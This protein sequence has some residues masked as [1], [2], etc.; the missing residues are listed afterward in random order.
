MNSAALLASRCALLASIAAQA[1][2]VTYERLQN[3]EP[4]NWLMNHHDYSSQRFSALDQINKSNIKNLQARLRHRA[5]GHL[6]QR[7]PRSDAAGR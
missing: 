7:G 6:R 5:V 2:D 3:P 4:Q 1:A